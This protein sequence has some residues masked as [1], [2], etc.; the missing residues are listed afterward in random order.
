M[1]RRPRP[2]IASG[3]SGRYA[4]PET[5][6][7]MAEDVKKAEPVDDGAQGD[8]PEM[9]VAIDRRLGGESGS[10]FVRAASGDLAVLGV[11]EGDFVLVSPASVENVD[12]GSI[13]VARVGGG[14]PFHRFV[15]NGKG[16]HLEAL[17]P[18]GDTMFVEDASNLRVIGRVTGLYRRMDDAPALNLTHH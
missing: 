1:A 12:D 6:P 18:G 9:Y 4:V 11:E 3:P 8:R 17:R 16:V 13:I 7:P 5:D 10:F 15:R 2:G 14:A